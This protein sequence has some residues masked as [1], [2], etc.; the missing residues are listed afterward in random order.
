MNRLILFRHGK[1]EPYSESGEDIDRRLAPRGEREAA[2]MGEN[3][4]DL[5]LTPDL[6]LVS[7][8]ART[9]DTWAA[10]APAFPAAEVRF[11]DE[12]YHADSLTVRRLAERAGRD[13]GT[14]M[15]VGHNPGLHELAVRMMVEGDA[16]SSLMSRAAR[17]F[18][19]ST[20]AVFRIDAAGAPSLEGLYYP[21]REG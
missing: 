5:G 1:A 16:P 6:A 11:D 18:P 4:A 20:V 14:V 3:L 10:A 12:L 7:T 17:G 19:T 9:R 21:E 13:H 8:A 15:V 2:A